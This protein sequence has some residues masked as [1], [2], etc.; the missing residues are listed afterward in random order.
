MDLL[1]APPPAGVI[2]LSGHELRAQLIAGRGSWDIGAEGGWTD[3]PDP[4]I[5]SAG[6]IGS[7]V[8]DDGYNVGAPG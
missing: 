5:H 4:S 7:D 2:A 3:L 6:T 1:R 8:W